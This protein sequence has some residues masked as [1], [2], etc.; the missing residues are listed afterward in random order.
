MKKLTTFIES[1]HNINISKSNSS[2]LSL[3][4]LS[5]FAGLYIAFGATFFTFVTAFEGTQSVV[6]V[7]GGLVFCVGLIL[8]VL[9]KAE[10]FTGNNLMIISLMSKKITLKDMLKNWSIV[11]FGNLIG[12]LFL[13]CLMVL[14][15]LLFE[16]NNLLGTRSLEIA[17]Y[18]VELTNLECFIRGVLCNILVCLAVWG[19]II[20]DSA[21]GKILSIIFPITTFVALGFEHS[22]A[23]MYFLPAGYA[24]QEALGNSVISL[25]DVL[26]NLSFVTLGNIVGGGV[27]VALLY[28]Y[29]FKD[30]FRK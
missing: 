17:S 16:N 21:Q 10:L 5:F 2:V 29:S 1:I 6:K 25:V 7:F 20:S 23:N 22:V 4:L 11:L 12:S 14:S 28:F 8:V 13:V 26:R 19:A 3:F 9:G 27:F 30:Q 18:K 24:I 15:G